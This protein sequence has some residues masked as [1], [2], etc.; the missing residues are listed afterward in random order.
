MIDF[1][2]STYYLILNTL[3]NGIVQ[4]LIATAIVSLLGFFKFNK[5]I[6]N[7]QSKPILQTFIYTNS[8]YIVCKEDNYTINQIPDILTEY[9]KRLYTTNNKKEELYFW[10]TRISTFI[11]F[12][13]GNR[14]L[15]LDRSKY[16]KNQIID[17]Q[18]L[19]CHGAVAFHNYSLKY[20]L[21]KNFMKSNILKLEE[22]PGI[23]LEYN[24]KKYLFGYLESK[25]EV[26]IMLGFIAYVN[27]SDLDKGLDNV[28]LKENFE[29]DNIIIS[30]SCLSP[31]DENL[32]AKIKLGIKHLQ[33]LANNSLES[34]R[35]VNCKRDNKAYQQ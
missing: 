6:E 22:I 31:E 21:S 24:V 35:S 15:V 10:R 34:E 1:L 26:A 11:L 23:S 7:L 2:I 19:D 3:S 33:P 13:D 5:Y 14:L 12:T 25:Q 29:N 17:N 32:T 9:R 8:H 16:K 27:P 28:G 30:L 18:K 20:K 4:S